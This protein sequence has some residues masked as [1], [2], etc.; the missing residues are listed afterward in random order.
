MVKQLQLLQKWSQIMGTGSAKKMTILIYQGSNHALNIVVSF[1][2]VRSLQNYFL[3]HNRK[4]GLAVT[5]L[6]NLRLV[7]IK[8]LHLHRNML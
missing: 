7:N 1:C 5:S 6:F 8:I 2:V 4:S 3:F